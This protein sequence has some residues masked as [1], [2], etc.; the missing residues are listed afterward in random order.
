MARYALITNYVDGEIKARR[1]YLVGSMLTPE[2]TVGRSPSND[3]G[4]FQVAHWGEA[5]Q[6]VSRIHCT[7]FLRGGEV[8]I[9]DGGTQPSKSGTYWGRQRL[10][11]GESCVALPL[12]MDHKI[13]AVEPSLKVVVR[14]S[15]RSQALAAPPED[16]TARISGNVYELACK[17]QELERAVEYLQSQIDELKGRG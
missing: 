16:D 6:T 17:I 15:E 9:K 3:L 13:I 14:V 1:E 10:D 12:D 4:H 5:L 7:L 2:V 8:F 11:Q